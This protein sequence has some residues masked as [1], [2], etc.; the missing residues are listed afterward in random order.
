[1]RIYLSWCSWGIILLLGASLQVVTSQTEGSRCSRVH[2]RYPLL[3]CILQQPAGNFC[4]RLPSCPAQ[5]RRIDEPRLLLT[6]WL[7]FP[8]V[9]VITT[10]VF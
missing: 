9:S 6:V 5:H 1:M 4:F 2:C 10:T 3:A 8:Y 7:E